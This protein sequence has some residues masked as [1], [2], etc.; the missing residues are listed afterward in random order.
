MESTAAAITKSSNTSFYYSFSLLPRQKREAIH[1]V[2]A[3]CRYTDDIVDEGTDEHSKVVRLRRWRM[4]LGRALRGTST[5]VILNQLSATARKF[6][7]PVDHFYDLIRGMEMDLS[8]TRYETFEELYRYCY[9]VASSV[10]LMC[11]QIFGYRNDSTRDYAVNLGVALQLTNILRDIKEDAKR[12]RIYIPAEDLRRFGYTEEDLLAFR[13]TPE[14]V[15]LMRFECDRASKYFDIA[16]AALGNEDKRFFFAARIMWSIY[17]HTLRRI[18]R[19]NYNVFERRISVPGLLK[20]LIAF[21]YWL[22]NT[23][24]Y[25]WLGRSWHPANPSPQTE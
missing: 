8:K 1:A 10:G 14:F 22:S 25:S 19:S 18:M 12:G 11:R 17:A 5:Y 16:R 3:F 4:E 7:I 24:K 2:Y 23:L 20:V 9:L 13:Y 21:R 15:N 6:N